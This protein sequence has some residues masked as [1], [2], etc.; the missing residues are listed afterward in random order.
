MVIRQPA[1]RK[2]LHPQNAKSATAWIVSFMA[3]SCLEKKKD[4][5]NTNGIQPASRQKFL[6]LQNAKSAAAWIRSFVAKCCVERIKY[7]INTNC[8]QTASRQKNSGS[9]VS[10]IT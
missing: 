3:K 9:T 4:K 7:K 8:I 6:D 5:V 2:F 1:A 10:G